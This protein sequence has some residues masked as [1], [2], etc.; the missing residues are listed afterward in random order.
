MGRVPGV[1][2]DQRTTTVSC[3]QGWIA[4]KNKWVPG[5]SLLEGIVT[6]PPAGRKMNGPKKNVGGVGVPKSV[7]AGS[8]L[9]VENRGGE[10]HTFTQVSRSPGAPRSARRLRTCSAAAAG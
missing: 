9:T 10:T 7:D 6:S 1:A 8:S 4:Q 5:V 2:S 3:I